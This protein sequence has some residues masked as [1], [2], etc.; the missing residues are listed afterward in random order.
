MQTL[1]LA[2]NLSLSHSLNHDLP[3]AKERDKNGRR[4]ILR[5]LNVAE[6]V[7]AASNR[8]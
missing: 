3:A 6:L 1:I 8:R 2:S 4:N 7:R 5:I